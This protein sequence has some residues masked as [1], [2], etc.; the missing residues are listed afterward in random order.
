MTGRYK[1]TLA[2]DQDRHSLVF[3]SAEAKASADVFLNIKKEPQVM[4]EALWEIKLLRSNKRSYASSRRRRVN[5]N[6]PIPAR[7]MKP[8]A[9]RGIRVATENVRSYCDWVWSDSPKLSC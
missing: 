8:A 4:P 9:G 1:P 2:P 3:T 7:P 6:P 5:A